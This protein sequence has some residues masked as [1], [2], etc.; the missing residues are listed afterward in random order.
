MRLRLGE[1]AE[2]EIEAL[3]RHPVLRDVLS[4]GVG[5]DVVFLQLLPPR[6]IVPEVP[7]TLKDP[8][9]ELGRTVLDLLQVGEVLRG[10]E[11]FPLPVAGARLHD[12]QVAVVDGAGDVGVVAPKLIPHHP[13]EHSHTQRMD[14]GD[15]PIRPVLPP[16]LQLFH[17]GID[18]A[19]RAVSAGLSALRHD[20]GVEL[21]HE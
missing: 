16:F 3:P 2:A 1:V 18:P 15:H 5:D 9:L 12:F 21:L 19:G 6:A 17:L 7:S 11:L 20:G 14:P 10:P 13:A 8:R 4:F